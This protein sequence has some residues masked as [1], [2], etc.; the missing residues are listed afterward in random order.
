MS[1]K[2]RVIIVGAGAAG[3]FAAYEL[4]KNDTL[5]IT[6]V[7][8]GYNVDQRRCMVPEK[9]ICAHCRPCHMLCGVGGAG[10]YSSGQL[11]LSPYIG[12]DLV[13][14]AGSEDEAWRLIKR[15]DDIFLTHGASEKVYEPSEKKIK[16]IKLK[17]GAV[18]I[19][20][21]PIKQRHI[22][23]ENSPNVINKIKEHLER[24]GVRFILGTKVE[25]LTNKSI[26]LSNSETMPFEYCL[27]APGRA[28]MRWLANQMERL[29]I[30]TRYEPVDIG[31]RIEIPSYIMD[32]IC[33]FQRDPKF[34]IST[35]TF[36]DFVR[37]FCTNHEGYVVQEV[38]DD[39]TVAVNGHSYLAD[40]KKSA[41]SNFAL[42]TRIALTEPLEDSTMYGESLVEA[43]T[44][45][46]GGKPIVQRL[47]DLKRGRR[48]TP[49]KIKRNRVKPT[50]N[51][52]TPGDISIV[53]P[54]RILTDL[55]ESIEKLNNVIEGLYNDSTLIYAPEIKYSAKRIIT[56]EFL[57]TE[58][59]NIFVAGDGAG[60]TRG[61]ISAAVS[62]LIASKGI[63]T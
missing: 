47:G 23:T 14:L 38:Y 4:A 32:S 5:D 21:I 42:L 28:G 12:G 16:E 53:M 22:G 58:I 39:K 3:L 15:V 50:L 61:I 37:T 33:S 44:I 49:E 27:L 62:G 29:G 9:L 48:S 13:Q 10:T 45:L 51:N 46:G 1:R 57:E 41:N 52:V 63:C 18:G 30:K 17:A 31:V 6:I 19:E 25:T 40:S 7:D 59:K 55:L 54:Y 36:D 20:F 60:V 35:Q 34:H 24:K 43:F 26:R 11:N 8:M 2:D 56:N